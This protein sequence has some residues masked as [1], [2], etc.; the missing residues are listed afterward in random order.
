M[1][2][3]HTLEM[4]LKTF[5]T[6]APG[7]DGRVGGWVGGEPMIPRGMGFFDVSMLAVFNAIYRGVNCVI[8]SV[9]FV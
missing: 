1:Y 2:K 5:C 3:L 6:D 9:C 4:K 7:G 8:L